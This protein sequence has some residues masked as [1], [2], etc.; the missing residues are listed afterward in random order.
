[1]PTGS[2]GDLLYALSMESLY[3]VFAMISFC[4]GQIYTNSGEKY[5]SAAQGLNY[6]QLTVVAL[7]LELDG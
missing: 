5:K 4:F 6:W 3:T 2:G 7:D 1:L